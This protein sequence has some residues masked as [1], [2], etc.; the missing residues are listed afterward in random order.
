MKLAFR[1]VGHHTCFEK[2]G[3]IQLYFSLVI[4][5]FIA[6][7]NKLARELE[8]SLWKGCTNALNHCD[9]TFSNTEV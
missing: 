8:V 3:I 4:Y 7:L 9:C 5:I 1:L 6:L 2:E